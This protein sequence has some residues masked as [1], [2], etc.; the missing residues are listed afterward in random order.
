MI[1]CTNI[2]QLNVI[3]YKISNMMRGIPNSQKRTKVLVYLE[4]HVPI[5]AIFLKETCYFN[6]SLFFPHG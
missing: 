3:Y 5:G 6:C 2:T 1:V 4:Q